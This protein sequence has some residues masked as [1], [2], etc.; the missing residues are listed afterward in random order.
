MAAL[1]AILKAGDNGE[2]AAV[3]AL[4]RLGPRASAAAPALVAVARSTK[5]YHRFKAIQALIRIDERHEA[6]LPALIAARVHRACSQ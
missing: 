6:I 1:I 5:S 4:G 3:E 2:E